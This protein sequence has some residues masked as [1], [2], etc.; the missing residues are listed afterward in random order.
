VMRARY[1]GRGRLTL[2]A[3]EPHGARARITIPLDPVATSG[4]VGDQPL[5]A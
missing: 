1:A 3:A 2:T 4:T 5:A